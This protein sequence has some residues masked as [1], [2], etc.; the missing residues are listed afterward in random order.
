MKIEIKDNK[1][2]F[3]GMW[4]L[5]DGHYGPNYASLTSLFKET[6]TDKL[7]KLIPNGVGLLKHVKK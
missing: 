4:I 6:Y 5:F 2:M 3:N 7:T 1:L